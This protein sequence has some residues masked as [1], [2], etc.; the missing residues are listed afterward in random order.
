MRRSWGVLFLTIAAWAFALKTGRELAYTVAYLIT[1]VIVL[2]FLWAWTGIRWVQVRRYTRAY[3]SQVGQFAEERFEVENR[4]RFTKLWLEVHDLSDLPGHHAS[5]VIN[6]LGGKRRQRW[7]VRTLCQR[8]GRF[9]LGPIVLASGDLLGLFRLERVLPATAA[10]TVYPATIALPG[11]APPV[12]ELPGGDAMRQRIHHVTT[13]VLGVREYQPGDPLN[14]IHWPS[15][16]RT[17]RLIAKE[18]ELDPTADVWIFLDMDQAVHVGTLE[19]PELDLQAPAVLWRNVPR[20]TLAPSTEEYGVTIAASVAR[21]FLVH[22]RAVGFVTHTQRREIVQADRGERQLLRILE[23]L[24]VIEARGRIP[25][26]D[27]LAMEG[28]HLHRNTTLVAITPSVSPE[29]V[30]ALRELR[31]RGVRSVAVLLAA[32]TF[33]PAPSWQETRVLLHANDI[34]TYVVRRG[35]Q[36]EVALAQPASV[37]PPRP[38]TGQTVPGNGHQAAPAAA[39]RSD[40]QGLRRS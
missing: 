4:S 5:R 12:G 36:I 14:R 28:R 2:S 24:A 20:V 39:K 25:F 32:N 1:A 8:R 17:G 23:T 18:F 22:N 16:A 3:R 38:W 10:L 9:T 40:D 31:R 29:W 35:D 33:G 27:V 34:P 7:L 6:S 15:T 19:F 26:A 13:N 21:H 11:F 37:E 30:L